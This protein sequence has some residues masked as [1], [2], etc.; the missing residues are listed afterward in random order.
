MHADVCTMEGWG[1]GGE[2]LPLP[3]SATP[4]RMGQEGP[5]AQLGMERVGES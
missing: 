5:P 1:A 4:L 2:E 3:L